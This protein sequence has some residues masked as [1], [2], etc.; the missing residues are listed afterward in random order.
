MTDI[1]HDTRTVRQTLG[2]S[3][4]FNFLLART[5]IRGHSIIMTRT[6][7][8]EGRGLSV[9]WKYGSVLRVRTTVLMMMKEME[10][11]ATI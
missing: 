9:T 2:R 4:K 10:M 6:G 7:G 1:E 8:G 3:L 11:R 5:T